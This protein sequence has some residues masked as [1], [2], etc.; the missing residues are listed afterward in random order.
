M[1]S[2]AN[3]FQNY[4]AGFRLKYGIFD[5]NKFVTFLIINAMN[6]VKNDG[7]K[8]RLF[9]LYEH[10][11]LAAQMEIN[12]RKPTPDFQSPSL[13]CIKTRQIYESR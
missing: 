7:A 12:S 5:N 13:F 4:A 2:Q 9:L 1:D 11:K 3:R 6:N 8:F 10:S